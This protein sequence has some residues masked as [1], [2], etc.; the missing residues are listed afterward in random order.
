MPLLAEASNAATVLAYVGTFV[1]GV[2]VAVIGNAMR[3]AGDTKARLEAK[4]G[5]VIAEKFDGLAS[6]IS[7]RLDNHADRIEQVEERI[8]EI[9]QERHEHELKMANQLAALQVAIAK[10]PTREDVQ[11]LAAKVDAL[12]TRV[13]QL[14]A[15]RPHAA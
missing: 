4:A 5:E 11:A 10:L 15:S 13:T 12:G 9:A 2:A 6:G 1:V 3:S 7:A 8:Q 14:A